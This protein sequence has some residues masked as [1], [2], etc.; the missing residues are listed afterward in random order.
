MLPSTHPQDDL[1][2]AIALARYSQE[3]EEVEPRNAH[4]AWQMAVKL[5]EQHGLDPSEAVLQ[6]EV[7]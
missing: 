4:R 2:T 6:L 5:T 7:K 3:F 1:I